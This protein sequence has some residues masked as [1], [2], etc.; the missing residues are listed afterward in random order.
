MIYKC[1]LPN[2]AMW[3]MKCQLGRSK[4]CVFVI[5]IG[6]FGFRNCQGKT[7]NQQYYIIVV[8]DFFNVTAI[9]LQ[10]NNTEQF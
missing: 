8:F 1:V 3:S 2:L 5:L 7:K 6:L 4:F 10:D 9:V